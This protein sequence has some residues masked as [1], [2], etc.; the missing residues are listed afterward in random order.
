MS[1]TFSV[2]YDDVNNGSASTHVARDPGS[3]YKLP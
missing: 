3:P 2:N 1:V